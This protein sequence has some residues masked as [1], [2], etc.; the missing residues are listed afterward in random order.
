MPRQLVCPVT[1]EAPLTLG[2][3]KMCELGDQGRPTI[4]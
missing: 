4:E 1:S 2:L 3:E